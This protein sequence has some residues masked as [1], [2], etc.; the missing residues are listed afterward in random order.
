M[1]RMISSGP[2]HHFFG[3]YGVDA[4]DPS[5]SKHLALKTEFDDHRPEPKDGV[6]VGL[7][8]RE[9]ER[10]LPLLKLPPL[11]FSKVA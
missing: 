11:T 9:K 8:D 2:K 10:L 5:L 1:I 7:I 3:Y 6:I 4:W